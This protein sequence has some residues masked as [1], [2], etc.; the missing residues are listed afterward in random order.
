MT[1]QACRTISNQYGSRDFPTFGKV[2]DYTPRVQRGLEFLLTFL[3]P[4]E[5]TVRA[6][7]TA[8]LN[9]LPTSPP[10]PPWPLIRSSATHWLTKSDE[11]DIRRVIYTYKCP[12]VPSSSWNEHALERL[13]ISHKLLASIGRKPLPP[14]SSVLAGLPTVVH[15]TCNN[16]RLSRH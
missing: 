16:R 3:S 15:L 5:N 13:P 9:F 12:R 10:C 8:K 2:G 4:G 7:R 6:K 1:T 11:P 14:T